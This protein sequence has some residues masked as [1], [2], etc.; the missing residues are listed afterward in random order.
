MSELSPVRPLEFVVPLPSSVYLLC[1]SWHGATLLSLLLGNHSRLFSLG[2][3]IPANRLFRC[4][5]GK[6]STDCPFWTE[7]VRVVAE[8]G[9]DTIIPARPRLLDNDAF[10]HAA[11]GTVTFLAWWLHMKPWGCATLAAANERFLQVCRQQKDFDFFIDGYKSIVRYLAL[12]AERR[13]PIAGIIHLIRDPRP[14]AAAGKRRGI[15]VETACRHWVQQHRRIDSVVRLFGEKALTLR[16]EDLCTDPEKHL[17]SILD[18][19]GVSR[20]LLIHS[21]DPERHWIGSASMRNFDGRL[22]L[23]ERW[24]DELSQRELDTI[25]RLAASEAFRRGYVI[26]R[27]E[28]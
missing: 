10:N 25:I 15:T 27:P 26:S 12:K 14:F 16:Y 7:V 6:I 20:E 28:I 21:I 8:S 5:C 2:D 22:K 23:S 24:R 17:A 9:D 1:P 11:I 4:R 3:T 19:L 13:Q 18:W